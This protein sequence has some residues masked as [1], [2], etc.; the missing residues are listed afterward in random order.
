MWYFV[1]SPF[2][3]YNGAYILQE[4]VRKRGSW[5]RGNILKLQGPK[6]EL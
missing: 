1:I 5:G 4:M 3:A 6:L 2:N